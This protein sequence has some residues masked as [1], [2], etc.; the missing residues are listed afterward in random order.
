MTFV[1]LYVDP[2]LLAVKDCVNVSSLY[3]LN[4]VMILFLA[5]S[6]KL[7]EYASDLGLFNISTYVRFMCPMSA[8][9][10]RM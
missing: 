3:S 10:S 5:V 7:L 4:L 8:S 9:L 6:F 2:R 1:P